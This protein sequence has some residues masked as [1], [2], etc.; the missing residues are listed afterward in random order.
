MGYGNAVK[1]LVRTMT[2][3]EQALLFE[4]ELTIANGLYT[5]VEVGNALAA[6]RDAKLYRDEFKTFEDYCREKWGIQ[7]AYAYRLIGAAEVVNVLSPIGDKIPATETQARPLTYLDRVE[8]VVAWK[9]AVETA[10]NGKVTAAHVAEVVREYRQ[11]AAPELEKPAPKMAVHFSS[12][13]PEHYTPQ[14]VVDAVVACMGAID[15]DPCADPG[16]HIPATNHYTIDDDG[17]TQVWA[18]RV[19]LN[20]PYGREIGLWVEKLVSEYERGNVTEAIALVPA[21]VDTQWWDRLSD[22]VVCM[23]IGRLTF[24]G[25]DDPAPFPSALFYLGEDIGRFHFNFRE[26]GKIWQVIEPGMFGE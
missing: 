24:I 13:T 5:F 16:C 20:P 11:P 19:Y 4:S 9:R 8:Q 12:E 7:R 18:G 2:D 26:L 21:R 1:Q 23:V 17:L 25:N 6:I 22:Y 3:E 10:P 14:G 15:L